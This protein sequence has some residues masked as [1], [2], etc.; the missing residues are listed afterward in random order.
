MKKAKH[1]FKIGD[2]V[3]HCNGTV[4]FISSVGEYIDSETNEP[5]GEFCYDLKNKLIGIP[6]RDLRLYNSGQLSYKIKKS[7]KEE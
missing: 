6:G 1:K 5:T 2:E 7:I 4:G 3:I